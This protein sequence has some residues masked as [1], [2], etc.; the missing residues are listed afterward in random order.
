MGQTSAT[1]NAPDSM[2]VHFIG[3]G[4]AGMSGIALVL[5][6]R[7]Y[8]VS[9][10]DLKKSR[11]IRQLIR[12]GVDIH[13]GHDAATI[14]EV[15]PDVVVVSTAIPETNPELMRAREL[16]IPVWPRAKMLSE[17]GHGYTT[18]AIAGT[19]GKTTTSSMCATM[20]DRMGLDPSFLIGGIVEGYDTNGR[21]GQGPHFVCEADESDKSFLYLDPDVVVVTNIEADHLDHYDSLDEIERTFAEFMGL[22]GEEGTVIACAES[23][24]LAELARGT[25]RRV[26]TYGTAADADVRCIPDE[27]TEG[28]AGGCTVRFPD[29]SERHVT[30]KANPGLHNLLNATASLTVAWVLDLDTAAAA[31]ALS[32]FAGVRRRFTHVGDIDGITV[33]D[34]YGHHPTEIKATLAAAARLG[35]PSVGVVFQPHRYS[36]LQAFA[37]DFADAFAEA[38]RLVLIDV[39]SAGEMP[40]PGV[41]SRMLADLVRERHPGKEV[42]YVGDRM[43]LPEVLAEV[44]KPGDLFITM[45]AGDVT[46]VGP[47]FIEYLSQREA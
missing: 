16:K 22:V 30:I 32:G 39:F 8:A 20:L 1:L 6:E 12:A 14:D 35:Y 33:V 25:G 43:K 24:H 23:P 11:Y 41:T 36:R 42:V 40:I 2:R 5:H 26:V 28:L 29:G 10:S 21:N 44:V 17:L 45:G 15:R 13:I 7:G 19:H 34:D 18:V 38:D 31:E 47:E 46:A 37:D 4:G 3:V 9:G 27:R